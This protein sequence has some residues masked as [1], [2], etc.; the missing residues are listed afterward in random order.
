MKV[1]VLKERKIHEY[2]VGLTPDCVRSYRL[3]SRCRR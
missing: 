2:R 1:A 3:W